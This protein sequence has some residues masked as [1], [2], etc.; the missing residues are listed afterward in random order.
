MTTGKGRPFGFPC[1]KILDIDRTP[2]EQGDKGIR[3][4]PSEAFDSR[5]SE[6]DIRS[7]VQNP[8]APT[9]GYDDET[10]L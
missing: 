10:L 1:R 7:W 8:C 3:S 5:V 9:G 6:N 4:I 2:L